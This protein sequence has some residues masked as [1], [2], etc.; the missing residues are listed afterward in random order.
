MG[1]LVINAIHQSGL[2]DNI[3]IDLS[4]TQRRCCIGGEEG[5]SHAAAENYY[6]A[7]F[8]MPY[9]TVADIGLGN[10]S[11]G[12]GSLNP[13]IHAHGLQCVTEGEGID[14][15]SQHTHVICPGT[16][17]AAAGTAPPEVASADYDCHF[18]TQ[19]HTFLDGSADGKHCI[20]VINS[21]MTI[22][23]QGFAAQFEQDSLVFGLHTCHSYRFITWR[24]L[25]RYYPYFT[26]IRHCCKEHFAVRTAVLT[27]HSGHIPVYY[28]IFPG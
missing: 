28:I 8:Q 16:V 3:G 5:T 18:H 7:L 25:P 19:I 12:D 13:Y 1:V 10:R 14:H 2:E 27:A 6:P 23:G 15:S 17:H 11:H 9:R 4:R 24:T 22:T 26:L 21:H 20:V